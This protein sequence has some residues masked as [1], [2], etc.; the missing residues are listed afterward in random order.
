VHLHRA[1]RS[2]TANPAVAATWDRNAN[3]ELG[4]DTYNKAGTSL[5]SQKFD[6]LQ[7]GVYDCTKTIPIGAGERAC[8]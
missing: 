6:P 8:P 5:A 7:T 4:P 3:G 1:A 2:P